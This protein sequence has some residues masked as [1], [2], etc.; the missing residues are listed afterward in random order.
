MDG[1]GF[2][3]ESF[4]ATL[5][6][7]R[8]ANMKCWYWLAKLKSRFMCGAYGEA[9]QAEARAT[10]Q[11]WSS[12]GRFQL[13]ELAFYGA[14]TT[15]ARYERMTPAEQ[16]PALESLRKAHQQ[17]A[18]WADFSPENFR[19]PERLVF[20]ELARLMGRESEAFRAYEEALQAARDQGFLQRVALA[21][22]LAAR[23]WYGRRMPTLADTYARRARDA[24]LR[25]GARGKVKQLEELWPH[26]GSVGSG[27]ATTTDTNSTQIDALTVVKAQQAISGE[28][29]LERLASTLLQV[30]IE[31]AGAQRG[32]LLLPRGDKL[33]VMA[34]SGT[35]PEEAT[36]SD[37]AS[38]PWTLLAYVKRAREQVL[39]DDASQPHA[40]SADPWLSSGQ[41]RSV[42]CLPLLRQQEFRGVLYLEHSLA[43]NAFTPAR[44]ALL[45]HIASQAA[46]SIENARLYSDVQR[47][48]AALRRANDELEKRVEERTRELRQAQAQLVETARSAGMAEVATNVLHNVGNVL[49]S[50]IVNAQLMNQTLGSSRLGRLKQLSALFEEHRK[51]LV[52]FLTRD[53]R[54]VKI[55]EYLSALTGELNREQSS[56]QEGMSA[57]GKHLEHIRAIVQL[58]QTYAHSTLITEECEL[59]LLAEDSLSIQMPALRRH[60]INV[61]RELSLPCRVRVDK[62]K[63]LQILINLISNAKNAMASLPQGTRNLQMRLEVDGGKALIRVVDNGM[64]IAPEVRARLFSQGFTT[65]ESGHGLGLHSSALA[66]RMLGGRLTLESEGP[67][68]G[69]TA[70]LE[71]PLPEESARSGGEGRDGLGPVIPG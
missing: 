58:Q 21:C 24:Y 43:T 59:S 28:I 63:V 29:V 56:L 18:E 30:A 20:A 15:A 46:I 36:G 48:E 34:T 54:G 22:E 23:F 13:T 49:T 39:I 17:L 8:A 2:S 4:E 47:A 6:P 45:G 14:L 57:M 1:E 60:G 33:S 41:V 50:A 66:A 10:E 32:A 68:L 7:E 38:L 37:E 61:V 35:T 44:N 71:L 64:G 3:E 70:T 51:G 5:K 40:F 12:R 19:A 65:R 16:G 62:H 26:I 67:G 31:N 25:W 53:P 52:D 11:S 69:A 42:L 9:S 27:D 55:P